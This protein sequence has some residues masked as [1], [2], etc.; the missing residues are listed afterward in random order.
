MK[1]S[2]TYAT[3]RADLGAAFMEFIMQP[4]RFIASQVLPV[5]PT[6]VKDSNFAAITRESIASTPDVKRSPKG[7]Y[8]RIEFETE[9]KS[10]TCDEYGLESRLPDQHR[11]L[12]K[13]D[14][15][16]E[17]ATVQGIGNILLLRQEIRVKDAL[18]N[19]STFTGASLYTD[20]SGAPWDAVGSDAIG[21]VKAASKVVL[22]N[23]GLKPNA[24][25]LGFDTFENL[26]LNTAIKAA[27]QYTKELTDEQLA[28]MIGPVL[29]VNRIIV[30]EAV[31]NS[32]KQGQA[33]S[34]AFVW[35]DDY[36]LLAVLPTDGKDLKQPALGR[37]FLWT[38]DSPENVTVEE[39]REEQTR[40]DVFRARHY[41]EEKVIDP[42]F[43]HLLKVDA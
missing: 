18:F 7:N 28:R 24:L 38:A 35:P 29:G 21:H 16:A 20:V 19:T 9:D 26:K 23:C 25:I 1:Q 42:Y 14:F 10:F 43:G 6:E 34:G 12:Y 2:G 3:P 22:K 36:A 41:L 8:A 11:N 37:T 27:I 15:D 33:M 31:Y 17:L 32:A 13:S 4:A 40:S 30:G 5:F 39:Y